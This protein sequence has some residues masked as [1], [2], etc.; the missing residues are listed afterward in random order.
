MSAGGSCKS[1]QA[2]TQAQLKP[3]SAPGLY[4]LVPSGLEPL[5]EV[6]EIILN[7]KVFQT[8]TGEDLFYVFHD[9][10][11]C[12]SSVHIT[13]KNQKRRDV[14]F[15]HLLSQGGCCDT[16]LSEMRIE[17]PR[18]FTIGYVKVSS[19]IN[20][21]MF[22]IQD[23]HREFQFT[24][25]L[26]SRLLQDQSIQ[27]LSAVGSHPVVKIS[28]YKK[29]NSQLTSFQFPWDMDAKM[30]AVILGAYLFMSYHLRQTSRDHSSGSGFDA[31][32]WASSWGDCGGGDCGD[33][34]GGDCGGGGDGGGGGE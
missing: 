19:S 16:F 18:T 22:S 23:M 26:S 3:E 2:M 31:G 20:K 9:R 34:G 33:G 4:P 6:D 13:L 32:D 27:I 11:C 25:E 12:G 5:I 29:N 8:R 28:R 30:K 24:A 21:L 10:E 15:L 1:R 7:K 17:A 14:V